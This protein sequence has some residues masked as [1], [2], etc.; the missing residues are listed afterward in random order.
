M[1]W[2]SFGRYRVLGVFSG[3]L[4]YFAEKLLYV[5]S[6]LMSYAHGFLF[7]HGSVQRSP[8]TQPL[9]YNTRCG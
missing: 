7:Y 8:R 9:L 4:L 5:K 2:M 3:L 6:R 1:S